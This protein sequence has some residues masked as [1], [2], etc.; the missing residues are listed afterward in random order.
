MRQLFYAGDN[1]FLQPD[2]DDRKLEDPITDLGVSNGQ[3][4]FNEN[5]YK[6][7][8][9]DL[10]YIENFGQ[11]FVAEITRYKGY[12]TGISDGSAYLNGETGVVRGTSGV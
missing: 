4:L 1:T 11:H 5:P 3:I 8:D 9:P 6:D 10:V 7:K 12:S 2:S